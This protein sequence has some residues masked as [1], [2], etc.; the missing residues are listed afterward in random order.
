MSSIR[1]MSRKG[2]TLVELLVVIAIVAILAALLLPALSRTEGFR[3]F[4]RDNELSVAGPTR[5][6]MF[7]EED[8][9]TMDDAW[10]LVTMDDSKPFASE[11]ARRH[12]GSYLLSFAEGHAEGYNLRDPDSQRLGLEGAQFSAQNTDWLRLKDATTIR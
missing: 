2:F 8:E 5:L 7:A 3:T 12:P 9:A 11:P 1:Y 4:V 10:F 6:W